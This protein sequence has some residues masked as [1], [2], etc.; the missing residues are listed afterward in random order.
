MTRKINRQK[1]KYTVYTVTKYK[2]KSKA[3]TFS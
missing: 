1:N 2:Y 3:V